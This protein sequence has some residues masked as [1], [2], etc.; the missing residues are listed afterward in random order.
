[1][2]PRS[3]WSA[4]WSQKYALQCFKRW[5]KNS[6]QNFLWLHMALPNC[7]VSQWCFLRIF[8]TGSKPSRRSITAAKRKEKEKKER[9]K[10]FKKLKILTRCRSLS[11]LEIL[12]SAHAWV[13]M[14]WNVLLVERKACCHVANPFL[15]D[16][17]Y[18]G[19]YPAW[20]SPKCPKHAF[21][22]KLVPGVNG[23]HVSY[24]ARLNLTWTNKPSFLWT[25][26]CRAFHPHMVHFLPHGP[27]HLAHFDR[28]C[29]C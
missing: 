12:I 16:W 20:K 5:V 18:C 27:L 24:H 15:V 19:P 28:G 13:Q 3:E 1:M 29:V 22:V 23:L 25:V 11:P 6:E 21:L 7:L 4:Q 26:L 2:I 14:S 10:N 9:G 17:S 8:W